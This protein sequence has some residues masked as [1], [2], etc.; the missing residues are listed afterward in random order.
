[1]RTTLGSGT[2]MVYVIIIISYS[3]LLE[4][5]QAQRESLTD[6]IN[7]FEKGIG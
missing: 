5:A 4:S 2:P 7:M 1:M 6:S 3:I